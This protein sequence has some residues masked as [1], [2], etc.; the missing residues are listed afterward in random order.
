MDLL[1]RDIVRAFGRG[2]RPDK[3]E[4]VL[5]DGFDELEK[6]SAVGFYSGKAWTDVLAHLQRLK[7]EPVFRG[8]YFLEE[9]SVLSPVALAYYARAHLEF[10]HET[11][12][13]ARPDEEF[14]FYFLGQLHQIVYMH[15][16]T[17]FS[18]TQTDVLRRMVARIGEKAAAGGAFEYFGDD[19]KHQAETVLAE[20]PH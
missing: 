8:A 1:H 17:P 10:L 9:W 15:K 20:I 2:E 14:V 7:D 13:T 5:A 6:E 12:A 16:G 11:L 4:L 3:S 18:P 19:I